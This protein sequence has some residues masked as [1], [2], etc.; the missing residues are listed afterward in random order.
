MQNE[1][2]KFSFTGKDLKALMLANGR[3]L[4]RSAS[5]LGISIKE[6][7]S[8]FEM[9][10]FE[11]D[12][13]MKIRDKLNLLNVVDM[14]GAITKDSLAWVQ[15]CKKYIKFQEER[16]DTLTRRLVFVLEII[17]DKLPH[18]HRKFNMAQEQENLKSYLALEKMEFDFK[19]RKK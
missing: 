15:S 9:E 7:K 11:D 6:L 5:I 13:I 18:I 17:E 19:S 10:S 1:N 2:E 3:S 4:T 14:P 16:L 12:F 8:Y